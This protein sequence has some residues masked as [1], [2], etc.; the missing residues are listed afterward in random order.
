MIINVDLL[1]ESSLTFSLV[2]VSFKLLLARLFISFSVELLLSREE[3]EEIEG[4]GNDNLLVLLLL[5]LLESSII[6]ESVGFVI[7]FSGVILELALF[8]S[9]LFVVELFI[10]SVSGIVLIRLF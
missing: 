2:L 3:I 8:S 4:D 1:V 5:L 6:E 10:T 9:R 7:L